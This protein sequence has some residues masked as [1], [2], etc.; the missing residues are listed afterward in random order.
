MIH[1]LLRFW[2][3]GGL[4]PPDRP[5]TYFITDYDERRTISVTIYDDGINDPDTFAEHLRKYIDAGSTGP[6]VCKVELT[7]TGEL[8]SVSSNADDNETLC[9]H[10]PPLQELEKPARVGIIA[11][12]E[13][14]ELQRLALNVDL[15]S[16]DADVL[17]YN[18]AKRENRE[19]VFKYYFQEHDLH[20]R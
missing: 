11:R 10:Y 5:N 12:S 16:Y 13:L 14:R 20:E 9:V 1:E 4:L 15:V 6:K 19:A 17:L 2:P 7:E 18:G 8:N 3:P